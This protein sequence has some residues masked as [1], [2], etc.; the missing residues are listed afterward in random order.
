MH[1]EDDQQVTVKLTY[2][3]GSNYSTTNWRRNQLMARIPVDS[4]R[5]F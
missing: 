1:W 4:V 2:V 3:R 5:A